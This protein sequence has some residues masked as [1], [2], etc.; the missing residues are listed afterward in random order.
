M[1]L[2]PAYRLH[3]GHFLTRQRN[4]NKVGV[5]EQRKR[6]RTRGTEKVEGFS[7]INGRELKERRGETDSKEV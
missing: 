2:L 5:E 6:V 7:E 1:A 3:S 4:K